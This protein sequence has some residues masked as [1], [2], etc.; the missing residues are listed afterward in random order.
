MFSVL[1]EISFNYGHRLLNYQG[2]CA[3]LHGHNGRVLIQLSTEKLNEQGMVKD[4][5]EIKQK[6]AAWI[7]TKLD[8]RMILCE[9]DPLAPMLQKM[10]EPVMLTAENPTVEVLARMIYQEARV[11]KLPVSK[12]TL[13]ESDHCAA[14]YSE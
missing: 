11:L 6:I 8:H 13:W 9:K 12:V 1:R 10:G 5:Y 4:F 7:D 2:K 3:H 14:E